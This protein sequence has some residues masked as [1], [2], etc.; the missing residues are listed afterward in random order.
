MSF[1][2]DPD[3]PL[4]SEFRR[5]A[6]EELGKAI[7]R[8]TAGDV[9]QTRTALKRL[10]ALLD[11]VLDATD[12]PT[13]AAQQRALRDIGRSLSETRDIQV[14]LATLEAMEADS[15]VLKTAPAS[16]L[17]EARVAVKALEHATPL[18]S[19]A[20]LGQLEFARH[21]LDEWLP[22]I[23]WKGVRNSV[24]RSYRRARRACRNARQSRQDSDGGGPPC[25][26]TAEAMH[27]LRKRLKMLW[28]QLRLVR[29]CWPHVIKEWIGEAE[30]IATLLGREHDLVILQTRLK[31][32]LPEESLALL[33]RAIDERRAHLDRDSLELA[34]RF[35]AEPA[36]FFVKRVFQKKPI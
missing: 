28:A 16:L 12:D 18:D 15:N 8:L 11:L 22:I 13:V 14:C 30:R 6:A 31:P 23:C 7:E 26:R 5:V 20:A 17:G 9:H 21:T 36:R 3:C 32:G 29:D 34:D 10:R 35:L 4:P 1:R 19:L 25:L 24:R 27:A 33:Q 2:F